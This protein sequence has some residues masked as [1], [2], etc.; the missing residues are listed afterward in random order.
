[1]EIHLRTNAIGMTIQFNGIILSSKNK[2]LEFIAD[3]K[4]PT[5]TLTTNKIE[6][7]ADE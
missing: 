4:Y 1:M 7:K 3:E 5:Y 2:T 6:Y